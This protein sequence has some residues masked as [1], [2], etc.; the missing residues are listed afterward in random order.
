MHNKRYMNLNIEENDYI[1]D[2][3]KIYLTSTCTFNRKNEKS[4]FILSDTYYCWHSLIELAID[5]KVKRMICKA[6]F[7]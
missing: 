4:P 6:L 2:M 7:N 5:E 1:F 3:F